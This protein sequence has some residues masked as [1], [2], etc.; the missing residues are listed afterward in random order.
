MLSLGNRR[1]GELSVL[2]SSLLWGLFPVVTILT[3]SQVPPMFSA[4][5][6]TLIAAMFFAGVLTARRRWHHMLVRK[7]WKGMLLTTLF[8][9]VLFY[10]FMFLGL[11][12]T[13][14][15]N[16]AIMALMEV[17]FSFLILGLVLRHEPLR[18]STVT[19]GILM[20]LGALFILLP[21]NSGWQSG[22]FLV[23]FATVFAPIGNKYSQEAR[24]YVSVECIMFVRSLLGGCALLALSLAL[25]P[26]P[27]A[28]AVQASMGFLLVNGI[29]LFGVSKILWIEGINLIPITE[30]ISLGSITPLFTLIT[31][32]FVLHE[33]VQLFQIAGLIP[34]LTGVFLL[35]RK[36][37]SP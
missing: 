20:M 24:K 7:A 37:Q 16:G 35:T 5:L 2:A 32:S 10:W 18:T 4:A 27:S 1:R 29:A 9:G 15:G 25:E 34:I 6:S 12:R 26:I 21:K 33:R 13:T 14:A 23:V 8:I 17:L 28:Q 30:A 3:F 19:G 22:D 31:A 11:Q 36:E